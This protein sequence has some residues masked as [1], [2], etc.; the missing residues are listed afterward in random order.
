MRF[1][2]PLPPSP[3]PGLY[4]RGSSAAG[5]NFLKARPRLKSRSRSRSPAGAASSTKGKLP[6]PPTSPGRGSRKSDRGSGRK[7]PGPGPKEKAKEKDKEK[8]KDGKRKKPEA[9]AEDADSDPMEEEATD[10]E[11][12]SAQS[13]DEEASEGGAGGKGKRA[14]KEDV[15]EQAL[16]LSVAFERKMNKVIA[17]VAKIHEASVGAFK[18]ALGTNTPGVTILLRNLVWKATIAQKVFPPDEELMK[19]PRLGEFCKANMKNN[20][21]IVLAAHRIMGGLTTT[22]EN[23]DKLWYVREEPPNLLKAGDGDATFEEVFNFA[24]NNKLQ[25]PEG[26]KKMDDASVVLATVMARSTEITTSSGLKAFTKDIAAYETTFSEL[27]KGYRRSV[28]NV[29]GGVKT[30]LNNKKLSEDKRVAEAGK[31]LKTFVKDLA[32]ALAKAESKANGQQIDIASNFFNLE[33][34]AFCKPVHEQ[35][36]V[37]FDCRARMKVDNKPF[38][39]K[40]MGHHNHHHQRH[41]HHPQR[42][43]QNQH[44]HR[45]HPRHQRQSH[46]HHRKRFAPRVPRR[47]QDFPRAPRRPGTPKIAQEGSVTDDG[48]R[49]PPRWPTMAPKMPRRLKDGQDGPFRARSGPHMFPRPRR[50]VAQGP[51]RRPKI[52]S[53]WHK[54]GPDP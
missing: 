54:T 6:P 22:D 33:F 11:D 40:D 45:Y 49:W 24:K 7:E 42:Q 47:F 35:S 20:D 46:Q 32:K 52:A 12:A 18:S 31:K 27:S 41:H 37:A 14:K 36:S 17:D 34:K 30:E 50:S 2:T 4:P 38:I 5:N 19:W 48:P 13:D 1:A 25:L 53:R 9:A 16:K 44:Q 8:D 21:T 39:I 28:T 3:G 23:G 15:G 10:P 51:P 29:Q 26:Y 43:H